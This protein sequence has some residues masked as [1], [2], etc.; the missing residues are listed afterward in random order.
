M[1]ERFEAGSRYPSRPALGAP[2]RAVAFTAPAF[3]VV[4][5][6]V[7][8]EEDAARFERAADLAE[9]PVQL[10]AGHRQERRVRETPLEPGGRQ[11][12]REKLL[13]QHLA[14]GDLASHRAEGGTALEPHRLVAQ[15]AKPDEIA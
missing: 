11:G 4:A 12:Q 6:G 15:R 1:P 2:V 13:L 7:R 9:H 3:F 5:A 14:P 10:A 8:G